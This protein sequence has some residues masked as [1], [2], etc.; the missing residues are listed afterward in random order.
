MTLPGSTKVYPAH[1][2]GSLCGKTT[3]PDLDS[4]IT[5]ELKTNYA[6]QPMSEQEFIKVLLEDLPFV[7]KYFGHDVQLNRQGADRGT[8][9][10]SAIYTVGAHQLEVAKASRAAYQQA[11]T[12]AG[13]GEITTEIAP[14]GTFYYAEDYHQQYLAKN[15]NG[16]CPVHATG[17]SCP[18]GL[19]VPADENG[20]TVAQTDVLPPSSVHSS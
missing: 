15:P 5:K 16:Y 8:Q 17:V 3:S 20:P 10:R 9:Y 1:G 11:L 13:H 19:G 4:T 18:I 2:P 14:L 12:A 7:P 6:L